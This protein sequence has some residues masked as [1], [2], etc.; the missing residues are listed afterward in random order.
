MADPV[1]EKETPKETITLASETAAIERN[2]ASEKEKTLENGEIKEIPT[3]ELETEDPE[4]EGD[5]TEET[6][7]TEED[8]ETKAKE[9]KKPKKNGFKRRIDKLNQRVSA[10]EQEREYWRQEALRAKEPAKTSS[11]EVKPDLST[12]PDKAKFATVDEYN[13]A[14][15]EWKADQIAEK[16]FSERE[17]K[18]NEAKIKEEFQTKAEAHRRRVVDFAKEKDDWEDVQDTFKKVQLPGW[19]EGLILESDDLSAQIVYELGKNP[20]ELEKL[21]KLSYGK[22]ER[23]LGRIEA[24]LATSSKTTK[25]ENKTGTLPKP[26]N[27]VKPKGGT[28]PKGYRDD[29]SQA[30]YNAWR[31]A[32][33]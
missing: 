13:E 26:I 8:L 33:K 21:S 22:A 19:F 7:E 25:K 28:I 18:S 24:R 11:P 4:T 6:E 16:K 3:E 32:K 2:L 30:E 10:V 31:A 27:P 29:M 17:R 1:V 23:A 12:K 14:L 15:I 20:E 5:E 9:D